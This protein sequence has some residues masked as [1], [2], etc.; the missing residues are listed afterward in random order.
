MSFLIP[1]IS[2]AC[3]AKQFTLLSGNL[4]RHSKMRGMNEYHR[5]ER[6][7]VVAHQGNNLI[8]ASFATAFAI[9]ARRTTASF[10]EHIVETAER[11]KTGTQRHIHYLL[12][13]SD[14]QLLSSCHAKS[15]HI[16]HESCPNYFAKQIHGVIRMETDRLADKLRRDLLGVVPRDEG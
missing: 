16:I 14:K 3:R 9:F 8:Q 6:N 15:R 13:R 2:L 10:L 5:N 1:G 12:V 11:V 4:H 7:Y